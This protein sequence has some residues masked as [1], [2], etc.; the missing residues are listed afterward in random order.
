METAVRHFLSDKEYA[1]DAPPVDEIIKVMNHI[2]KNNTFIF[3]NQVYKQIFGTAMGTPMAPSISSLFMG[4]LEERLLAN[5]PVPIDPK[6]WKRFLDDIFLLWTGTDEEWEIF[7][8]YINSFHSTIKFTSQISSSE[9]SFLDLLTKLLNGYIHTD[10]YT[11]S[12]DAHS[13][14][15]FSSCH[16]SH[17]K[18]NIPY[19]Q[20]LRLRRICSKEEDFRMRCEEFSKYFLERGYKKSV[21]ERAVK[22]AS[23][24]PRADTLI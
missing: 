22:R 13:Y 14:L 12:T 7:F 6:F 8:N 1:A 3:E 15:H 19:S 9:L 10:L 16:P 21:I 2:L 20:M 4:W 24:Q 11:K 23:L 17:C 18:N 5:S